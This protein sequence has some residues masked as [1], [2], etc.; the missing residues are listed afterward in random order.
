LAAN[1]EF[2]S[3]E[4]RRQLDAIPSL[5]EVERLPQWLASL[6][7]PAPEQGREPAGDAGRDLM[8]ALRSQCLLGAERARQRIQWSQVL[9][10][11]CA[12]LADLDFT[13]LY[14]PAREL[15]SVGY[16]VSH[17]RLDAT[18]YDLLASEARLTSYVA[19]ALG[20]LKQEHW[21]AMGRLL[22]S[23]SGLATLISWSGSMFEYLM[24]LLVLP[25]Y[26]GTL[27]DSSH[28]GAEACPGGCRNPAIN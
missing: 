2:L 7:P 28:R 6:S 18:C 10:Q 13:H 26:G 3:G 25:V 22:V 19:I 16:N 27:L 5:Q 24:P 12:E 17:H 15:L 11:R 14:N 21:F 8:K 20:Q 9:A 4:A 23:Q 1:L